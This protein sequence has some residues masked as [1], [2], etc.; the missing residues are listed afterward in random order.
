M[1]FPNTVLFVSR[2]WPRRLRAMET[3]NGCT[4]IA[5]SDNAEPVYFGPSETPVPMW[6]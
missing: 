1:T 4:I 2:G 3:V 5:T 6:R